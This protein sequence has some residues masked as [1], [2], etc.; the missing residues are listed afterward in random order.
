MEL[1]E[2]AL[3]FELGPNKGSTGRRDGP[4]AVAADQYSLSEDKE[5]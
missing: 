2:F 1:C 4:K 3:A 5:N